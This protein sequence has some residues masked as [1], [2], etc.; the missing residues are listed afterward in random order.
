MQRKE[1]MAPGPVKVWF[2]TQSGPGFWAQPGSG[3]FWGLITISL[4]LKQVLVQAWSHG[5]G[6]GTDRWTELRLCVCGR[7]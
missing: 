3:W 5:P 1:K 2:W 4:T 6:P 7:V